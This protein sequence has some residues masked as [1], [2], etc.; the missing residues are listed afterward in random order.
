ML[1]RGH[2]KSTRTTRRKCVDHCLEPR[3]ST[4]GS[5]KQRGCMNT[6]L[7]PAPNPRRSAGFGT[8]R[9]TNLCVLHG[10]KLCP[11]AHKCHRM[12]RQKWSRRQVLLA[13]GHLLLLKETPIPHAAPARHLLQYQVLRQNKY[14]IDC[15]PDTHN[16]NAIMPVWPY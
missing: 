13:I 4:C 1:L 16:N 3:V 6:R 11:H 15:C 14:L 9:N 8:R 7:Y 2:S 10:R 12:A 5:C